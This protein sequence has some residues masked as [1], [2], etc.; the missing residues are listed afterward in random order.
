MIIHH[1]NSENFSFS[2]IP[3]IDEI[4]YANFSVFI[5]QTQIQNW[6]P[7]QHAPGTNRISSRNIFREQ[8]ELWHENSGS[9]CHQ[10]FL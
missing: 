4:E 8:A 9:M 3:N 6:L 2:D 7:I 1:F 5:Y 10:H